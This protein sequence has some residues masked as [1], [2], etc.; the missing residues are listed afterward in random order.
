MSKLPE[1][2]AGYVPIYAAA[3]MVEANLVRSVLEAAGIPVAI[4]T[5]SA[6]PVF[7]LTVGEMGRADV[8]VPADRQAE[9]EEIITRLNTP[10]DDEPASGESAE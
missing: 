7:G 8:W 5:E 10:G 1:A 6:G 9:A 2:R 3:G 4:F